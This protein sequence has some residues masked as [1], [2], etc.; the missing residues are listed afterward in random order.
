MAQRNRNT[1]T[2]ILLIVSVISLPLGQALASRVR[3]HSCSATIRNA[4]RR[5]R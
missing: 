4:A 1:R 3:W 2:F 5:S